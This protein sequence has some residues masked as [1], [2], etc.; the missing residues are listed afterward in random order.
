MTLVVLFCF[1]FLAGV[2]IMKR[3]FREVELQVQVSN[4]PDERCIDDLN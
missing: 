1:C 3:T 4:V 2:E